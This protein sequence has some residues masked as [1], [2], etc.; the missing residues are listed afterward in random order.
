MFVALFLLVCLMAHCSGESKQKRA[1]RNAGLPGF[2]QDQLDKFKEKVDKEHN[3]LKKEWD[4]QREKEEKEGKAR[5]A[6]VEKDHEKKAKFWT[7]TM[8]IAISV[9][10]GIILLVILGVTVG[11]IMCIKGSRRPAPAYA[12]YQGGRVRGG[13]DEKREMDGR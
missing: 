7:N 8:I 11:V 5:R 13:R 4:E 10:A 3:Q 9:T 2:G 12:G 6:K 1:E